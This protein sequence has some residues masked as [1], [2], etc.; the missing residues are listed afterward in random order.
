MGLV[1]LA[2][3]AAAVEENVLVQLDN[4]KTHPAVA[5]AL[6]REQINLHSWVYEFETGKVFAFD[7]PAGQFIPIENMTSG[8]R[9]HPHEVDI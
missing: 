6:A 1:L 4:L 9:P 5:A 3:A 7:T 8:P 2:A